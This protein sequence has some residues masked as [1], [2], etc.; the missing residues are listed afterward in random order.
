MQFVRVDGLTV[1]G[2]TVPLSGQNMAL[3]SVAE[4]CGVNVSGNSFPGGVERG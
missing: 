1:T 4:S 2:N 3:A